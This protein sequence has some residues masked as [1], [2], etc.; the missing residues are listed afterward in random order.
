MKS[1]WNW[2]LV[3][4]G[5]AFLVITGAIVLTGP[6]ASSA[7]PAPR[8]VPLDRAGLPEIAKANVMN[9]AREAGIDPSSVVEVGGVGSGKYRRGVF[10]G[11][12][13]SGGM[14]VA[15]SHGFG[16][17]P[18][19]PSTEL[20]DAGDP[21]VITE[22]FSG[23]SSEVK[24]VGLVGVVQPSISRVTIGRRDGTS[25]DVGFT[26]APQGNLRFFATY[27]D[28]PASFPTFVRAYAES[29]VLMDTYG[30]A[31][32]PLCKRSNPGCVG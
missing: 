28:T 11:T 9:S 3:P 31:A 18:F 22:G 19:K 12:D 1:R 20:F 2:L 29:G 5:V 16:L 13:R 30:S 26:Q 32:K 8:I 23:P 17:I 10:V 6:D 21:M 15:L 4:I 7:N 27:S 24:S 25:A 14:Q